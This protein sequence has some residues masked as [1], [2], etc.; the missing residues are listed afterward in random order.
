MMP[1]V[2]FKKYFLRLYIFYIFIVTRLDFI[3]LLKFF[4]I[5]LFF[6]RGQISV[7]LFVINLKPNTPLPS[8][9]KRNQFA[10]IADVLDTSEGTVEFDKKSRFQRNSSSNSWQASKLKVFYWIPKD[11][12]SLAAKVNGLKK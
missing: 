12:H 10:S 3:I 5:E 6:S 9:V 8:F 2:Y 11:P 7:T 1:K 4:Y